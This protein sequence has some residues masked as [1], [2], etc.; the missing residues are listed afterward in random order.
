MQYRPE[1]DGLRAIAVLTVVIYHAEF[2]VFGGTFL[3]G[4]FVGVDVF[5]V[6]SGYLISTLIFEELASTGRFSILGFYERR[7]RRILPALFAVILVSLPFAW[8]LLLPSALEEFAH[9]VVAALL[10]YANIFFHFSTAEYG[11]EWSLLKPLLHT[12]SLSVEEQFYLFFPFLAI[13]LHRISRFW[14]TI[15]LALSVVSFAFAISVDRTHP[16]LNFYLLPSRIWELLAGVLVA[17]MVLRHGRASASGLHFFLPTAGFVMI[18]S[19]SVFFSDTTPHPSYPTLIPVLGTCLILFFAKPDVGIGRLLATGPFV[20]VGLMSY[21]L[22]LWH[23]PALAFLRIG[24]GEPSNIAL[25]LTIL[26]VVGLSWLTYLFVE[27]PFRQRERISGHN[28]VRTTAYGLVS[29]GLICAVVINQQGNFGQFDHLRAVLPNFEIDN[30]KLDKARTEF[31]ESNFPG[32]PYAP[33]TAKILVVGNS[34]AKD[35]FN[36]FLRN[37]EKFPAL[38]MALQ[39]IQMSCFNQALRPG[40]EFFTSPEYLL[41]DVV[42]IAPQ[43]ALGRKCHVVDSYFQNDLTGTEALVVRAKS[44]GK[45][46]ALVGNTVEFGDINGQTV[47]DAIVWERVL[48]GSDVSGLALEVNRSYF[49]ARFSHR[50]GILEL[51]SVLREIALRHDALFLSKEDFICERSDEVCFGITDDGFKVFSDYGHFTNEGAAF[52][53]K[54]IAEIGWLDPLYARLGLD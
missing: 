5:F 12:W 4:G 20:T 30:R 40:T 18:C 48:A 54:R 41:A 31:M 6:I 26:G 22:Y 11:A 32:I 34:H 3:T 36:A 1:I 52:F 17:V 38:S 14:V 21:S 15:L 29:L 49:Q 10:F 13:I 37:K 35:M 9:S 44:D 47:I 33:N 23:F 46:V 25:L 28:V 2:E 50:E 19:A 53:G 51:N 43:Y 16:N 42:F 39:D 8:A 24:L 45:Q 27:Q 7:A